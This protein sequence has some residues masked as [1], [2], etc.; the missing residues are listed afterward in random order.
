[1]TGSDANSA[2]GEARVYTD[3]NPYAGEY[4]VHIPLIE[5]PARFNRRTKKLVKQS[6]WLTMND[7]D[8]WHRRKKLTEYYRAA[9]IRAAVEAGLPAMGQAHMEYWVSYGNNRRL[10]PHNYM[11]TAKA[12]VD[13]FIEYGLLPDDSSKFLTGPDPRRDESLP[14]GLTMRIFKIG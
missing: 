13:G 10:D 6:P 9:G 1:M 11:L 3:T 8:S 5:L 12:V 7:R 2:N 4:A 14:V